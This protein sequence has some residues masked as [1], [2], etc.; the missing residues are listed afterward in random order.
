M[1]VMKGEIFMKRQLQGIALIFF[2][3]L[4]ML[5]NI[6]YEPWYD[7]DI[8]GLVA[9]IV[10]VL[11]VCGDGIVVLLDKMNENDDMKGS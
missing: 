1:F 2:G 7:V 9:G 10:G 11:L 5:F 6:S 8:L 3:V 4:L